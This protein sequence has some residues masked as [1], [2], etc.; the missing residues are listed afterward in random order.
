MDLLGF[1]AI[2][3]VSLVDVTQSNTRTFDSS[4]HGD[5]SEVKG[6]TTFPLVQKT[7]SLQNSKESQF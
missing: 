7:P 5:L 3:H 6:L 1:S 2:G 4:V